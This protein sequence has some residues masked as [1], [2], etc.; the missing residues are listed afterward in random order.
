M[1]YYV[2]I[3]V[4]VYVY[5]LGHEPRPFVLSYFTFYAYL[6]MFLC[7]LEIHGLQRLP[8]EWLMSVPDFAIVTLEGLALR[9]PRLNIVY[10]S[11]PSIFKTLIIFP[12]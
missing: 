12:L 7:L 5:V 9:L 8:E 10:S 4:Y 11:T 2:F 6:S 1:L 3:Y